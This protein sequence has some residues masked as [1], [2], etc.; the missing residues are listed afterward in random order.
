M[1]FRSSFIEQIDKLYDKGI[2]DV[3]TMIE[4]DGKLEDAKVSVNMNKEQ[5]EDYIGTLKKELDIN[6]MDLGEY[7][8]H[9]DKIDENYDTKTEVAKIRNRAV[10]FKIKKNQKIIRFVAIKQFK[11]FLAKPEGK[12]HLGVVTHI[13]SKKKHK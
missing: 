2:V 12:L 5:L 10:E 8:F 3:P 11:N 13:T 9:D 1:N 6:Y 7:Y 4:R